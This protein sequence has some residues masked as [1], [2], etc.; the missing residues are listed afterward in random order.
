MLQAKEPQVPALLFAM[1]EKHF[2]EKAS[3]QR[4]PAKPPGFDDLHAAPF[5]KSR[6]RGRR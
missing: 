6:T 2:Q 4:F 3:T 1:Q 5:T